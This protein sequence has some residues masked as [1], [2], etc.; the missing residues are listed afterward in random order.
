MVLGIRRQWKR[1]CHTGE[2][3]GGKIRSW[4]QKKPPRGGDPDRD[5]LAVGQPKEGLS[6]ADSPGE[7]FWAVIRQFLRWQESHKAPQTLILINSE[8]QPLGA[9]PPQ[10]P[11]HPAQ[12]RQWSVWATE[13]SVPDTLRGRPL[14]GGEGSGVFF[15]L[16]SFFLSFFL[17][18]SLPPFLPSFLSFLGLPEPHS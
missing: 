12:L 10:T 14:L 15:L 4:G 7:Q 3:V 17:P 6:L 1:G 11:R 9:P 8:S 16:L 2:L 5:L 13:K 18:P